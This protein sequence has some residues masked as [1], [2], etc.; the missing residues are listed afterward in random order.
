MVDG[1]WLALKMKERSESNFGWS[2]TSCLQNARE[3]SMGKFFFVIL[4]FSEL[5]NYKITKEIT[6]N[7]FT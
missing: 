5:Q 1:G 6:K 3:I 2:V 4:G 7:V